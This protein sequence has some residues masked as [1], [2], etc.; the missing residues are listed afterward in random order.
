MAPEARRQP[1]GSVGAQPEDDDFGTEPGGRG[2]SFGKARAKAEP[3]SKWERVPRG[4]P[5]PGCQVGLSQRASPAAS[6][7]MKLLLIGNLEPGSVS[8][9][10]HHPARLRCPL[11]TPPARGCS[12]SAG[13]A[14]GR[15]VEQP[16]WVP[17]LASQHSHCGQATPICPYPLGCSHLPGPTCRSGFLLEMP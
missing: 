6:P 10:L 12:G 16:S 13:Q 2:L 1:G 8:L 11:P 14:S 7:R 15:V 9:Q 17:V 5:G 3:T 4:P